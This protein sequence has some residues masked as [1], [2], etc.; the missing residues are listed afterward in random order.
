MIVQVV[1]HFYAC[2]VV[3]VVFHSDTRNVVQF[4]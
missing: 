4:V 3:R 2:M 1:Q